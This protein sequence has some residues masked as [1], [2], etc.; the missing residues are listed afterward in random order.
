MAY[1]CPHNWC[2]ETEYRGVPGSAADW[3]ILIEV[4]TIRHDRCVWG[5][6]NSG[7]LQPTGSQSLGEFALLP[8]NHF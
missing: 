6:H 1:A 8:A 7:L 4:R 2:V 3:T 5:H